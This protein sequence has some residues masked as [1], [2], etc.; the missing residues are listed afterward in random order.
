MRVIIYTR[1]S[2]QDQS[3]AGQL[4]ELRGLVKARPGWTIAGEYSDV[5]SGSRD[6]RPGLEAVM[7]AVAHRLVD[8]VMCAKI[9][10]LARSLAHFAKLAGEFT[11]YDVALI[12]PGQGIDTSKSNPCGR[13]QMNILAAVAE[14]ER[15]LIRE[16]TRSGIAVARAKGRKI[17][18]PSLKL[19]ASWEERAEIV[20]V[21]HKAGRVGGYRVLGELLGGVSP[22]TAFWVAKRVPNL[23]SGPEP[24]A[25]LPGLRA[26]PEIIDFE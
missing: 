18:R 5:M 3:C 14:F 22:G 2:T 6:D 23:D 26:N 20:R 13:F 4:M 21:W 16:R 11:K 12:V 8:G 24:T 15:D 7:E 19:P 25:E 1:V 10:R 17:G 9:D